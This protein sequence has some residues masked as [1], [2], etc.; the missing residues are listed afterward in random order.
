MRSLFGQSKPQESVRPSAPSRGK[1]KLTVKTRPLPGDEKGQV[2]LFPAPPAGAS[3]SESSG[4]D[5]VLKLIV[6][7][8]CLA[9]GATG[10]AIA[11]AGKDEMICRASVGTT[12]P[13]LGTCFEINRGLTGLCVS[14]QEIQRCEDALNDPRVD[15]STSRQ[16]GIRSLLLLPLVRQG[17]VAGVFELFSSRARAFADRDEQTLIALSS[18]VLHKLERV[19]TSPAVPETVPPTVSELRLEE[20]VH[21]KPPEPALERPAENGPSALVVPPRR[22]IVGIVLSAAIVFCAFLLVAVVILHPNFRRTRTGGTP[23]S[24]AAATSKDAAPSTLGQTPANAQLSVA[25]NHAPVDTPGTYSRPASKSASG[26]A[27]AVH[28]PDSPPPLPPGSLQ[29]FEKGKEVFRLL[30]DGSAPSASPVVPAGTVQKAAMIELPAS[31]VDRNVIYRVEPR[32]PPEA[33]SLKIEGTVLLDVQI[34]PNGLVQSIK[35]HSG[36]P[37][38]AQ[39]A[40]EAVRQWRFRQQVVAGKPVAMQAQ[41]SLSF[42]LPR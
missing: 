27:S 2:S 24:S 4:L 1:P 12:A 38:L 36:D 6:E 8:A 13:A 17:T 34:S 19:A 20:T 40:S 16:L 11:L 25:D 39:A 9:T 35:P 21:S 33:I 5:V 30:P 29:V 28:H 42:M 23:T 37:L 10:A 18:R 22:D 31:D 15:S 14:S 3:N 32:Y 7:Q 26:D 41:V